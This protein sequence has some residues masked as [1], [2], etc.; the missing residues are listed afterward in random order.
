MERKILLLPFLS[1]VFVACADRGF[2]APL[3]SLQDEKPTTTYAPPEPTSRL[4]NNNKVVEGVSTPG[5]FSFSLDGKAAKANLKGNILIKAVD[6]AVLNVPID[7]E[8]VI[9]PETL[10]GI[11][12]S[13]NAEQLNAMGVQ[14]GASLTCLDENCAESFIDLYVKYKGY[15][16]HHQLQVNGSKVGVEPTP[17]PSPTMTPA[18]PKVEDRQSEAPTVPKTPQR[19][20]FPLGQQT[21]N[22]NDNDDGSQFEHDIDDESE[23]VTYVGDPQNDIFVL[24]PETKAKETTPVPKTP[25]KGESKDVKTTE[26]DKDKPVPTGTLDMVKAA[27]KGLGQAVTAVGKNNYIRGHLENPANVL[28][29]ERAHQEPGFRILYPKREAYYSTDDMRNVL[30]S[31]GQYNK[32]FMN[33]YVTIIG[34]ISA[35][36]GGKLGRH[37]SHQM[38]LDADIA[39][40]FADQSKQKGLVDAVSSSKPIGAFMAAEQWALFKAMVAQGNV[41]RI[42]IHSALKKE[43]CKVAVRNGDLKESAT[44][45]VAFETLRVLRPESNH[46]NHFHLRLKCSTAQPRCRQMAPPTKTTGC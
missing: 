16:Y 44:D 18:N 20:I 28:E 7:V 27:L 38:G 22:D 23:A 8:G 19:P 5:N 26:G 15:I 10:N 9:A 29:Y 41:D 17:T 3:V 4:V 46:D 30:A 37:T 24:F 31:M 35:K 13:M 25:T 6:G 1:F 14:S 40:Y 12:P 11:M 2:Q 43:L 36:R 45:G 21:Q 39:Y 34:D 32:K 42:F 33:G